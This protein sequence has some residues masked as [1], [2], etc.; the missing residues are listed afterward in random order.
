MPTDSDE[1]IVNE[2]GDILL[3]LFPEDA[4]A[5][6]AD[7]TVDTNYA[8][9]NV[10]VVKQSGAIPIPGGPGL[11]RTV[12]NVGKLILK[13]RELMVE[14]GEAAFFGFRITIQRDGEF[15]VELTY[16]QPDYS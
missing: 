7:A 8:G 14:E 5:I 13:L 4:D 16:N 9:V 2:I 11:S 3:D 15:D 1:E 12:Y 6:I 10:S